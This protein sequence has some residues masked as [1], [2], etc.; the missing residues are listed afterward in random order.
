MDQRPE[1]LR[2][3][4]TAAAKEYIVAH[5]TA[6][7]LAEKKL[8]DL[9]GELAKWKGR[10]DLARA[11][12]EED[13][14]LQAEGEAARIAQ[15][16]ERIVAEAEELRSQIK[17]MRHQLPGLAA[18][19]RSVDPDLLEQELLIAA[20]GM[21]GEADASTAADQATDADTDRKLSNI[22][23]NLLADAALAALKA[24]MKGE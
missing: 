15:D 16:R 14:A 11:K 10:V 22:E 24:K 2:G 20:G 9:D 6:L 19:E 5:I 4:E 18:R 3:M 1:D 21:P 13:L 23:R 7:K 8:A 12:G 17:S